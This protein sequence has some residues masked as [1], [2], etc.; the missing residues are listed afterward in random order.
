MISGKL[1]KITIISL[2]VIYLHGIEEIIMGFWKIDSVMTI[3]ANHFESIPKAVYYSTHI[4]FW[5]LLLPM[6]LL[7]LGGRWV[8]RMMMLFGVIFFIE[9]HHIIGALLITKS[10]YPGMLTAFLYPIIGF[11]YW[12]ELISNMRQK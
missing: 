4:P 3:L 11:F 6:F 8:L 5:L 7:V 1:K 9:L 2:I 12:R 10:Y